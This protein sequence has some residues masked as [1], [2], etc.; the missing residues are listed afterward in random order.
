MTAIA[1]VWNRDGGSVSHRVLEYLSAQLADIGPDGDRILVAGSV[2]MVHRRFDTNAT[3]RAVPQPVQAS[4]GTMIVLAGRLDNADDLSRRLYMGVSPRT[5]AELVLEAYRRWNT[6][7]L[8]DLVGDFAL[9]LWNAHARELVLCVDGMGRGVLY[10]HVDERA[11]Y[12][13]SRSRPLVHVAQLSG[14]VDEEYVASYIANEV[15]DGS[16]FRGVDYLP[17]GHVLVVRERGAERRRYWTLSPDR[18]IRYRSDGEYEEHFRALFRTAVACRIR[19]DGPVMCELSG[20]LDSSSIAGMARTLVACEPGT[21]PALHTVSYV[22]PNAAF[23]DETGFIRAMEAHLGQPGLHVND[24]DCPLLTPL[25]TTLITDHPTP[26]VL[27]LSRW[28]RVSQEMAHL[29]AR[30]LLS[31]IGG[32]QVFCSP[33]ADRVGLADYAA[34]GQWRR[35]LRECRVWSLA[36]R[37]PYLA[38]LWRDGCRPLLPPRLQASVRST[39]T[40]REPAA[41]WFERSFVRRTRLHE[42]LLPPRDDVGFRQPSSKFLYRQIRRTVRPYL[43]AC[44]S[45]GHYETRY[46]YLDR[47]IVEFAMA[48]PFE[49]KV[50]PGESRSI[51]RRSLTSCVPRNVLART[52]KSGPGEA[53]LRALDREWPRIAALFERPRVAALGIVNAGRFRTHLG[54]ARHGRV[55]LESQLFRVIALEMWLE[56]IER[57]QSGFARLA[58]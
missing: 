26:A 25:P 12:W 46:P 38:V 44:P 17:A 50:R 20:G 32:D 56:M 5:S 28:N 54:L 35:L 22:F 51:V 39:W 14:E 7:M 9:A 45:T 24:T 49:Q 3:D 37:R 4:D 48:I 1:G 8:P 41:E 21:A 11:V 47:R 6:A 10:Y 29:G 15:P 18:E 31:G 53:L 57:T 30:V 36:S 58:S 19:T 23:A 2:G 42:R 55:E 27:F 13:C 33:A 16:P 43:G 34:S 40:R 52:S